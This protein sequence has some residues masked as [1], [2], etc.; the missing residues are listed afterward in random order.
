ML[1]KMGTLGN[2]FLYSFKSEVYFLNP[3]DTTVKCTLSTNS[4]VL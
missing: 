3:D 1:N 2:T 4:R